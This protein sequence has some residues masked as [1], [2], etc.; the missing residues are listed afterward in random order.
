MTDNSV[1]ALAANGSNLFAGTDTAG[2]FL[3]TNN[4]TSWTAVS[5]GMTKI[6]VNTLVVNDSNLF[7]GTSGGAFLSTNNGTSWKSVG[8]GGV[9]ALAVNGA[10]LFA[11]V[12]GGVYLSTNNGTSWTAVNT[13][14]TNGGTI[15]VLS[16]AVSSTNLFAGTYAG[17]WQRPLS[18]MTAVK[19]SESEIPSEFSLSQNYPNPFNPTTSI[20]FSL[21]ARSFVSLKVFDI[22][23]REVS[24]IVSE[25]LQAGSYTRQWNAAQMAN[26]VYFYCLQAGTFSEIKKLVFLK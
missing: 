1:T 13:G 8:L 7:A 9:N 3:S 14:L 19:L 23:G 18:Q 25:E 21:P 5:T 16:L 10:N 2:V 22:L 11:G 20:S 26:G 12:T 6:Y 24:T 15:T 4:G 17:V